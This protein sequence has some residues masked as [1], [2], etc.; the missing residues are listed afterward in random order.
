MAVRTFHFNEF[1]VDGVAHTYLPASF[2][3]VNEQWGVRSTS[4]PTLD[5]KN[6]IVIEQAASNNNEPYSGKR[7]IHRQAWKA[8]WEQE[9]F[10]SFDMYDHLR[11]LYT[12]QKTFWLQ[13]DD[14]MSRDGARL[15]TMGDDFR[16]Y[17]TPTYPIAPYGYDPQNQVRYNGTI[18]KNGYPLP[19]NTYWVDSELGIVR[20]TSDKPALTITDEITMAYTWRSFVRILSFDMRPVSKVAQ[21]GYVGTIVFEQVKPNTSYDPWRTNYTRDMSLDASGNLYYQDSL[22]FSGGTWLSDISQISAIWGD[23]RYF[24]DNGSNPIISYVDSGNTGCGSAGDISCLTMTTLS[25]SLL[26]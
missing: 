11:E 8:D 25:G 2:T 18:F 15:E 24:T 14:E 5:L 20:I 1:I 16:S 13:Y 22:V 6:V 23:T 3:N 12:L 17:F 10:M 9:A 26:I 7:K 4:Y 21:T 19:S